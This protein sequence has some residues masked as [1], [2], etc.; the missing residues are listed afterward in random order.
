M[1]GSIAPHIISIAA[2]R[3]ETTPQAIR[4]PNR[5]KELV[6]ARAFVAQVLRRDGWSLPRIGRVLGARHHTT[7]I[8][9]LKP[10][11]HR[12]PAEAVVIPDLSGEWAI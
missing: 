10:R 5:S 4:G 3:F 7:V 6:A 12:K 1:S 8:N 2:A 11:S 9:L